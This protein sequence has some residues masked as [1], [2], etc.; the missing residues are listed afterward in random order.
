MA[1]V[2]KG[3][4]VLGGHEFA[5]KDCKETKIFIFDNDEDED[6]GRDIITKTISMDVWFEEGEFGDETVSPELIINEFPTGKDDPD[7]FVGMEFEV[8]TVDEAEERE[9]TMYVFEHEPLMNYKWK[10][11]DKE[12][13]IFHVTVSGTAITDGYADPEQTAEFEGEF[14]IKSK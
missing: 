9:D 5:V 4:L 12:G 11:L 13:D 1:N 14:W 10:I 2:Q 6:E 8:K 7:D 3:K